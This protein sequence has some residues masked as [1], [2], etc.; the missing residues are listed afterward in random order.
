MGA[1]AGRRARSEHEAD[2]AWGPHVTGRIRPEY[3]GCDH[4]RMLDPGP[5]ATIGEILSAEPRD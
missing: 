1:V 4:D 3:L 5:A 2:E